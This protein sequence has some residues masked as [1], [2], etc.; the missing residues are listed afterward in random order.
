LISENF[1]VSSVALFATANPEYCNMVAKVVH[2]A[3]SVYASFLES[4]E[5]TGFAGQVS[6]LESD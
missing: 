1:P 2:K 6:I 4:P 5:G 3:N